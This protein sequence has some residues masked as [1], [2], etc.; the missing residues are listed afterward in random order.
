[1]KAR[2]NHVGQVVPDLDR[3]IA[4]YELFGAEFVLEDRFLG[5]ETSRGLGLD[6]ADARCAMMTVGDSVIEL[7]QYVN[8]PSG[9]IDI[10]IS[11]A[12]AAHLAIEV[13]NIDDAFAELAAAGVRFETPPIHIAE[14]VFA[15]NAWCYGYGPDGIMVEL[16]QPGDSIKRALWDSP[17]PARPS[18]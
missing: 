12:G 14:G 6:Q 13:D 7:I 18:S 4:F 16:Q 17:R 15:G 1:V 5:A 10:A 9:S 11:D 2:L 8:P 3:A